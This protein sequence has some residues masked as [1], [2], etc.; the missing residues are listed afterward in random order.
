MTE[1]ITPNRP[2]AQ[3]KPDGRKSNPGRGDGLG[4]ALDH[5]IQTGP[6][7][8]PLLEIASA[9]WIVHNHGQY[10]REVVPPIRKNSRGRKP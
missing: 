10:P 2:T 6:D 4:F 5:A 3:D 1:T 9:T 7:D 8:A